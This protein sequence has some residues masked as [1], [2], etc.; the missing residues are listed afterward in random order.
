MVGAV[1]GLK[2]YMYAILLQCASSSYFML[3]VHEMQERSITD[4]RSRLLIFHIEPISYCSVFR[5]R[6]DQHN[7]SELSGQLSV[8]FY[9]S[10]KE[11]GGPVVL[12]R[13]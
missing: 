11:G 8:E 13:Q 2:D 1:L 7:Q 12:W 9:D 5:D 10:Y 6:L 4:A 3:A